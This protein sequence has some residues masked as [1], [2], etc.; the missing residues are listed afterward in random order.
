MIRN[1]YLQLV[2][3]IIFFVAFPIMIL[4]QLAW[5]L[6]AGLS[7]TVVESSNVN[8]NNYS[9][10]PGMYIGACLNVP[11]SNKFGLI[12]S[13]DFSQNSFHRKMR[14]YSFGIGY[15]LSKKERETLLK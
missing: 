5:E 6:R 8:H 1:V 15:T 3:T 10:G 13:I 11:I 14:N 4:S 12:S 9:G 2:L 7:T